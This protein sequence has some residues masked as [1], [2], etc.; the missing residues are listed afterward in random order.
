MSRELRKRITYWFFLIAG[1]IGVCMQMQMY[2]KGDLIL[3][4]SN[5]IVT[6]VFTMFILRPNILIE[7]FKM[8][9]SRFSNNKCNHD[10]S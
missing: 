8:I 4:I 1:I 5:G 3:N 10:A 7:A 9:I 6:S 2:Y